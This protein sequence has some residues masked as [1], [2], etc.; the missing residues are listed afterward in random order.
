[1]AP[2]VINSVCDNSLAKASGSDVIF[3]MDAQS[4]KPGYGYQ[5]SKG[6]TSLTEAWDALRSSS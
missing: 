3:A 6:A 5:Q 4:D 1:M 2:A